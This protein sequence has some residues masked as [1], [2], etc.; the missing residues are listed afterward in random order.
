HHE[1]KY[2]RGEDFLPINA[3]IHINDRDYRIDSVDFVNGTVSLQD[4]TMA[5]EVRYPLFRT[6]SVDYVRSYYE[7]QYPDPA[8]VVEVDASEVTEGSAME[9]F[10]SDPSAQERSAQDNPGNV[11]DGETNTQEPENAEETEVSSLQEQPE[12]MYLKL[13]DLQERQLSL[14]NDV[15]KRSSRQFLMPCRN[16]GPTTETIHRSRSM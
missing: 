16:P 15:R 4:M 9:A 7:E 11:S 5:R 3:E 10:A 12:G 6:E 14:P 1:T 13:E 2:F 8:P